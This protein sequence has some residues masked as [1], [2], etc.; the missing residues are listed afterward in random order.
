MQRGLRLQKQQFKGA[1]QGERELNQS[2]DDDFIFSRAQLAS[3]S[4]FDKH[5]RFGDFR[6]C[7]DSVAAAMP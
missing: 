6:A 2:E 4:P 1:A 7:R 3:L 5:K